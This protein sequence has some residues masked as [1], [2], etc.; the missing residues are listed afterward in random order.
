[1]ASVRYQQNRFYT[2]WAKKREIS[3]P[4]NSPRL[5]SF[6]IVQ[7]NRR[8]LRAA[9]CIVVT[10][11]LVKQFNVRFHLFFSQKNIISFK[12]R[13]CVCETHDTAYIKII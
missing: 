11:P 10:T 4:I 12:A 9:C 13:F 5:E 7:I 8:E 1:M 3:A 6:N 2:P